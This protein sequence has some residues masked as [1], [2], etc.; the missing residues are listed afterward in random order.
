MTYDRDITVVIATLGEESLL[1][2]VVSI[3][4]GSVV[5]YKK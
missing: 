4:N 1:Q 3:L 5:P 2:T